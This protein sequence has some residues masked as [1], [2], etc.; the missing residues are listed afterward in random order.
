MAFDQQPDADR[1]RLAHD[2]TQQKDNQQA[3]G[4]A[5]LALIARASRFGDAAGG[6]NTGG[7]IGRGREV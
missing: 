5:P 7:T 1:D 6:I 4:F 3:H 2:Q